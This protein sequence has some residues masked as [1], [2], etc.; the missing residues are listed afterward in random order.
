MMNKTNFCFNILELVF[1]NI[2]KLCYLN[3]KPAGSL[4]A[5]CP[6]V[7]RACPGGSLYAECAREQGYL[8]Y[9]LDIPSHSLK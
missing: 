7:A 9:K 6:V 3:F 1:S 4:H 2:V 5:R 8:A